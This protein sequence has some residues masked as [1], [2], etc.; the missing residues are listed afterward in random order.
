MS[1]VSTRAGTRRKDGGF[2]V[3]AKSTRPVRAAGGLP[4]G[5]RLAR[6]QVDPDGPVLV[7]E[8]RIETLAFG[9]DHEPFGVAV[10]FEPGF[11]LELLRIENANGLVAGSGD[12][13][14]LGGRDVGESVRHGVEAMT[15]SPREAAGM[16]RTDR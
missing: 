8:V 7:L 14:L 15:G 6:P 10:E 9:V 11:L 1:S 5:D 13:D 16:K 4:D 12:P 2:G 3:E